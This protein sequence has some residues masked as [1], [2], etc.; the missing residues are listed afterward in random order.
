MNQDEKDKLFA[1]AEEIMSA[2]RQIWD[3]DPENVRAGFELIFKAAQTDGR[4][5]VLEAAR[6]LAGVSQEKDRK[7]LTEASGALEALDPLKVLGDWCELDRENNRYHVS[8]VETGSP[9]LRYM[10]NMWHGRE[11]THT[12][13]FG[14]DNEDCLRKSAQ[15]AIHEIEQSA[16]E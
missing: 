11:S 2:F 8:P 16:R 10:A 6:A 15:W 1:E 12:R 3:V 9:L 13:I 5:S 4:E 7:S 14:S